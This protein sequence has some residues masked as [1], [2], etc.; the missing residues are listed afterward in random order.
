[1][2]IPITSNFTLNAQLPLDSRTVVADTTER[3][4]IPDIRRYDGLTVYCT[5]NNKTYQLQGGIDNTKWVDISV[6]GLYLP[7]NETTLKGGV[8]NLYT[9]PTLSV[10]D[11]YL[12]PNGWVT[13]LFSDGEWNEYVPTRSTDAYAGS[14][15]LKFNG[16]DP[17]CVDFTKISSLT[18]E[19]S[20]LSYLSEYGAK[21]YSKATSSGKLFVGYMIQD[22]GYTESDTY[23]WNF[24]TSS[25]DN[26]T[27]NE[28]S[29]NGFETWT[30]TDPNNWTSE[31]FGVG[32]S[33]SKE[34]TLVHSGSNALS[35][36]SSG[37]GSGYVLYTDSISV[38]ESARYSIGTWVRGASGG[39]QAIVFIVNGSK[40]KV[41][42]FSTKTWVSYTWGSIPAY[43]YT[44][45]CT[46][47]YQKREFYIDTESGQSDLRVVI[48]GDINLGSSKT[49]YFD[50]L[51]L[52]QE[53]FDIGTPLTSNYFY[54]PSLTSSW[55]QYTVPSFTLTVSGVTNILS[56]YISFANDVYI[57]NLEFLETGLSTNLYTNGTMEVW[58]T[59]YTGKLTNFSTL[60]T[61]NKRYYIERETG[62]YHSS[63]VCAK[64][65]NESNAGLVGIGQLK[66]VTPS[67]VYYFS[68]WAKGNSG[69]EN[70]KIVANNEDPTVTTP[71]KSWRFTDSTWQ[72]VYPP[73]SDYQ[74]SVA[75][76]TSWQLIQFSITAPSDGQMWIGT[77][78]E[79]GQSCVI[80]VDDMSLTK[81]GAFD[82]YNMTN[83]SSLD[84][85]NYTDYLFS[86]KML[87]DD[88][89]AF[90]LDGAGHITT[91]W[92]DGFGYGNHLY[93]LA[94]GTATSVS[95]LKD[96]YDLSLYSSAWDGLSQAILGKW[97]MIA[98]AVFGG[99]S[100]WNLSYNGSAKMYIDNS[101]N[102]FIS[103]SVNTYALNAIQ[104]SISIVGNIS[105]STY[106]QAVHIGNKEMIVEQSL[107][108]IVNVKNGPI[109]GY[110]VTSPS[111]RFTGT[112][113]N[114]CTYIAGSYT[115]SSSKT[116]KIVI[117]GVGSGPMG[118]DTFKWNDD[119][120]E[121]YPPSQS[122]IPMGSPTTLSD[123]LTIYFSYA[124]GHAL[125]DK[126][127]IISTQ[128]SNVSYINSRGGWCMGINCDS[129]DFPYT[130]SIISAADSGYTQT[131]QY[132][133]HGLMVENK[134][135]ASVTAYG[136][137][138]H[139]CTYSSTSSIGSYGTCGVNSSYDTGA[140]IGLYGNSAST[141]ESGSNI[142]VAG[143]AAN[144]KNNYCFYSLAGEHLTNGGHI[145]KI[146]AI[147]AESGWLTTSDY[148]VAKSS[149]T[150]GGDVITI[151]YSLIG[152]G[153]MFI[154]K[155]ESGLC[156][157]DYPV[158]LFPELGYGTKIEGDY[159]YVMNSPY[160]S[161]QLY[162]N[163]VDWFIY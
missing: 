12:Y 67:D 110:G 60:T 145:V 147:G 122:G 161:V 74:Y 140:A 159:V 119:G 104:G 46:T 19:V 108:R 154:I 149:I 8:T 34:T 120:S 82:I 75:L 100:R 117:D 85:L 78:T 121:T 128:A 66:S 163:G 77:L 97:T 69:G 27:P 146:R 1:M 24:T 129:A 41:Y 29:N 50:D 142:A 157:A 56:I 40:N 116:W 16:D 86:L 95:P 103:N 91:D 11:E 13:V 20:G 114:D 131:S 130:L 138:G 73:S 81:S 57:D 47:S 133:S 79:H 134:S 94:T 87:G 22:A 127:E 135:G 23:L 72:T 10:W 83:L 43:Y 89:Y 151:P 62:T 51:Y 153:R 5:S 28:I 158:L 30:L 137:E 54:R 113:A 25:W 3:D 36:V 15:S 76:T 99:N 111:Y 38:D 160:Q 155:D 2:S 6:S 112:G 143:Y 125:G 45:D 58:N 33:F 141:H 96:S 109:S 148:I 80:F 37:S 126:W 132:I 156:S 48:S 53:N 63:P 68:I 162:S 21:F 107:S 52:I 9:D 71:T 44:L 106:G 88:K 18:T 49:V 14:Y 7:Y 90:K 4:A 64:L 152:S 17:L 123:G 61:D 35:I 101:G 118:Q 150:Y 55:T 39:E 26:L 144:G 42:D 92:A 98:K 70:I 31:N 84:S 59:G 32:G 115:G 65:V 139:G 124:T 105:E 102:L 136:I 93:M